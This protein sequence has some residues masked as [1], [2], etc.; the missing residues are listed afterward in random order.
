MWP[1]D[2]GPIRQLAHCWHHQRPRNGDLDGRDRLHGV[3]RA[4]A[5]DPLY[6]WRCAVLEPE[7]RPTECGRNSHYRW[8]A[9]A[10][11]VTV[12][13]WPLCLLHFLYFTPISPL[14][15][16]VLLCFPLAY[17]EL[18]REYESQGQGSSR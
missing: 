3:D 7:E 13:G 9:D 1:I 18:D 4:T 6:F 16:S 12:S 8:S 11:C 5:A 2:A 15:Y 14:F 10:T 17:Q